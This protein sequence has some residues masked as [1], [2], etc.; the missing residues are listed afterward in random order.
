MNLSTNNLLFLGFIIM[1]GVSM[2][3][4]F[5]QARAVD[6][7][8]DVASVNAKIKKLRM[9][10]SEED[11]SEEKRK[12]LQEKAEE[13][14]KE[15]LQEQRQGAMNAMAALPN[16]AVIWTFLSQFGAGLF[17]LG[18]L[19]VFLRTEESPIV[20]STALILIGGITLTFILGRFVY[21]II[22]GTGGVGSSF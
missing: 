16:G 7:M 13:L 20:R 5:K 8:G 11:V 2:M 6:A 18:V 10:M 12:K 17:G 22:G 9:E 15:D 4:S 19:S 3:L 1:A 21:L 14:Q